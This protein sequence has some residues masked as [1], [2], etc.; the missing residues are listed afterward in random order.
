MAEI[1]VKSHFHGL[2]GQMHIFVNFH[3]SNYF[4]QKVTSKT[5]KKAQK[6][7]F[8]SKIEKIEK[9]EKIDFSC[10]YS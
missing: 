7:V 4:D 2:Q 5:R 9:N 6:Y 8:R 10:I 3:V 1:S